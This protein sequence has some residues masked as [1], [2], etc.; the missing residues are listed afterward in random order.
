MNKDILTALTERYAGRVRT[1]ESL[2][3][4]LARLEHPER[5][6]PCVHIAGTN[7]KGSVTAM[8][9]SMLRAKGLRTGRFTSPALSRIHER[10][11]LDAEPVSDALM[12]ACA[13][14]AL[15]AERALGLMLTAFDRLTLTALCVFK[16]EHVDVA[17]LECGMGGR[18]DSTNV[19]TPVLSVL[20]A[21]DMDHT[22]FLGDTLCAIAREKCGIIKPGVPVVSACQ[23][24][25]VGE[26]IRG[27]CARQNAALFWSVGVETTQSDINSQ[28]LRFGDGVEARIA[29]SGAYQAQNA[30]L[31]YT[32]A[33][34]LP[35]G[36]RP[37]TAAVQ[38]GLEHAKWPGR[39]QW[40]PGDT[41]VLLDGAHNPQGARALADAVR[42][43]LPGREAVL[44]C[45][46][47]ED[48]DAAGMA[49]QFARFA[50]KAVAV[51]V[52]ERSMP[53]EKLCGVLA[54]AGVSA[55][56]AKDT[57]AAIA[58][59]KRLAGPGGLVVAAG[60]LY[61]VGE[62]VGL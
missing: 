45:C 56:P 13:R 27:T 37:D 33:K 29:L 62:L 53:P 26:I 21:I 55:S 22:R 54:S 48:K 30:A 20:S 46:I 61:L 32:A 57:H 50:S 52:D 24:P 4:M 15:D 31:A 8:L 5:A 7:G 38:T 28:A 12:E 51:A 17:L 58:E 36:L 42:T 11:A 1:M 41:D 18:L 44:L 16:R 34:R 43:L 19:V 35:I 10:I 14:E 9:E 40:L 49:R 47:S 2:G 25:E 39:M 60:S 6:Y 23:Q 3:D 59:A